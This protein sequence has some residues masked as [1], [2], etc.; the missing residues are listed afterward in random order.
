LRKEF[1]VTIEK[2]ALQDEKIIFITGDLGYNAFEGLQLS[3][4]DRFI[5][6]GVAEQNMVSVAAG[7]AYKGYKIFCYSI[8]PFIVYRCLEQFRNDVCLHNLP[9]CLVGNGGGYGYGIMGSIHHALEDLACISGMQNVKCWMPAFNGDVEKMLPNILNENRPAYLRL[10]NSK[11][12]SVNQVWSSHF[13]AIAK[14]SKAKATIIVLGSLVNNTLDA[15]RDKNMEGRFDVFTVISLPMIISQDVKKSIAESKNVVV[16]EEHIS[17]GGIAQQLAVRL[18][19]QEIK[20]DNFV[21]LHAQGYPGGLYGDQAFHQKQ[22]GLDPDNIKNVLLK[23][24]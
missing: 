21:S 3:L 23:F 1:A 9:V 16:I 17:V 18:L 14:S 5:N 12:A 20:V 8:A 7:L 6:A 19:E 2:L 22:S 24:V 4:K 11:P 13:N 15:L 10:N